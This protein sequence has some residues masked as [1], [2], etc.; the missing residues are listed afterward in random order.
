MRVILEDEAIRRQLNEL[1]KA[2]TNVDSTGVP[3]RPQID[4]HY[5]ELS[6]WTTDTGILMHRCS[7]HIQ[8]HVDAPPSATSQRTKDEPP[9]WQC[10]AWDE[11]RERCGSLHYFHDAPLDGGIASGS[12][13]TTRTLAALLGAVLGR[14][15]SA[16]NAR[17]AMCGGLGQEALLPFNPR[18]DLDDAGFVYC[19]MGSSRPTLSIW[20]L[21]TAMAV[22]KGDVEIGHLHAIHDGLDCSTFCDMAKANSQRWKCNAFAGTSE[23]AFATNIRHHYLVAF[24][25]HLRDFGLTSL[26]ARSAENPKASRQFHPLT[27]NVLE[28]PRERGPRHGAD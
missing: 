10:Q 11:V 22:I 6:D 5:H 28:R 24:H 1:V 4:T 17:V 26:C 9:D 23:K 19:K 3:P 13:A 8:R 2:I 21:W 25:L 15:W 16:T 18:P 7:L 20:T 27:L 12:D 14:R